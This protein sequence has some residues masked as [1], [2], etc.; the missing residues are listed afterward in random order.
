MPKNKIEEQQKV[1]KDTGHP[2]YKIVFSDLK[3]IFQLMLTNKPKLFE[4][5]STE[6]Y[7]K[8]NESCLRLVPCN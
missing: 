7:L 8:I 4:L 6:L 3:L 5:C 2:F 1:T